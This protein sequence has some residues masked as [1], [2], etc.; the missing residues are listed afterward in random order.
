MNKNISQK[1][2]FTFHCHFLHGTKWKRA[3]QTVKPTLIRN[4]LLIFCP[5]SGFT[6]PIYNVSFIVLLHPLI[7]NY[8]M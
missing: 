3:G 6:S 7:K 8:L 2:K 5:Y 4:V 1:Y